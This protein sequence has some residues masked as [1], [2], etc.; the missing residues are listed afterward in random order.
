MRHPQLLAK[1]ATSGLVVTDGVA[2]TDAYPLLS[3]RAIWNPTSL[4]LATPY[5]VVGCWG[6]ARSSRRQGRAGSSTPSVRGAAKCGA[7]GRRSGILIFSQGCMTAP[8]HLY[9]LRCLQAISRKRG[10]RQQYKFHRN[11]CDFQTPSHPTEVAEMFDPG[12]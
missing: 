10:P 9:T 8:R 12:G 11:F 3:V 7:A 6:C 2:V 4:N 1:R 5:E